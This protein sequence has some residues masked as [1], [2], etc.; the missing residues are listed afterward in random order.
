M[1]LPAGCRAE[2]FCLSALAL[3]RARSFLS[4]HFFGKRWN[5]AAEMVIQRAVAQLPEST[6]S[7]GGRRLV[8]QWQ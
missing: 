8:Y 1:R 2:G 3:D 6:E 5:Y 7:H 4:G